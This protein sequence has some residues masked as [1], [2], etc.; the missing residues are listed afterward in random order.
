MI[1]GP[2]KWD[3]L[4]HNVGV[5]NWNPFKQL[6]LKRPGKLRQFEFCPHFP[7]LHSSISEKMLFCIIFCKK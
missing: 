4:T 5:D 3:L 7:C 6:H 2:I 1:D